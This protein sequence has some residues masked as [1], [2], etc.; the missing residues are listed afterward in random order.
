MK[1]IWTPDRERALDITFNCNLSAKHSVQLRDF[2]E[3]NPRS[4]N[5][6]DCVRAFARKKRIDG[7]RLCDALA[8][9]DITTDEQ[10]AAVLVAPFLTRPLWEF[11]VD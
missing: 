11:E 5:A 3:R 10:A 6:L 8:M 1:M 7:K 9:H 4:Q 2:L